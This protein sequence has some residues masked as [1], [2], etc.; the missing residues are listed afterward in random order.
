M[1]LLKWSEKTDLHDDF[2][3][4]IICNSVDEFVQKHLNPDIEEWN[5]FE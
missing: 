5:H 3:Y 2:P 4:T 1:K